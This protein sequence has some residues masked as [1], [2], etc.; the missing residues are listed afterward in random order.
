MLDSTVV[1]RRAFGCEWGV[2]FR[3]RTARDNPCPT[4]EN[5]R[6]SYTL[7]NHLLPGALRKAWGRRGEAAGASRGAPQASAHAAASRGRA[8]ASLVRDRVR[9]RVRG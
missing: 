5:C 6:F 4:T 7:I 8:R 9:V 3:I 2:L 1:C